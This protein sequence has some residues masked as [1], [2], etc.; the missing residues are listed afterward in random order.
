MK[1]KIV[2]T[3]KDLYSTRFE[4]KSINTVAKFISAQGNGE[5]ILNIIITFKNEENERKNQTIH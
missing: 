2:K 1:Y 4:F 3:T 5:N